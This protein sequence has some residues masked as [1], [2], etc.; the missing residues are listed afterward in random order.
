MGK[1]KNVGGRRKLGWFG[2]W[3]WVVDSRQKSA[4]KVTLTC[5]GNEG[6]GRV[7]L[8]GLRTKD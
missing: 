4:K 5:G 7:V 3:E 8:G 6:R 2:T 1:K